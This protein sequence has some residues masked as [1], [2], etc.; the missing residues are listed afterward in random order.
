MTSEVG[1]IGWVLQALGGEAIQK[2]ESM[3]RKGKMKKLIFLP[4]GG[5]NTGI[6]RLWVVQENLQPTKSI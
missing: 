6:R 5:T 3:V 2:K 1:K 4:A